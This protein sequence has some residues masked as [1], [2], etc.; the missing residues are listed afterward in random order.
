M[1][2]PEDLV[3]SIQHLTIENP[4]DRR[5]ALEA[6]ADPDNTTP[7]TI[8]WLAALVNRKGVKFSDENP[9]HAGPTKWPIE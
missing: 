3:E 1:E 6:I 2:I 5:L 8:A 7:A 9:L 4:S